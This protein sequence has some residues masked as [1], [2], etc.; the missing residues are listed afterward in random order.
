MTEDCGTCKFY[1]DSDIRGG[2]L[3][4]YGV[5]RRYPTA[6]STTDGGWCGEHVAVAVEA[7]D[8][9]AVYRKLQRVLVQSPVASQEHSEDEQ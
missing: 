1:R 2:V 6:S 3:S 4:G 7:R 9:E 5:C 8:P